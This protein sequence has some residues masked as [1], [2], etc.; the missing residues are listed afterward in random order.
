MESAIYNGLKHHFPN[1]GRL[2]CVQHL[3][4]RDES[5]LAKLLAETN[6]NA[7]QRNKSSSDILKDI[8]GY[9]IGGYYG[10]GLAVRS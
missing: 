2:L 4:K 7:I 9:R 6:R 3:S 1:L 8:Y 10:Y 5:K